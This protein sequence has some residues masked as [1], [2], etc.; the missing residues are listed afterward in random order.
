M[1][2]M[3][4]INKINEFAQ[5]VFSSMPEGLK[6]LPKDLQKNLR[7]AI[8]IAFE[9]MDLVTREEFDAQRKVLQRSREKLDALEK[10]ITELEK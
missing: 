3:V 9:K 6:N 8:Q 4:D 10:K 2:V 7:S 1:I 5:N